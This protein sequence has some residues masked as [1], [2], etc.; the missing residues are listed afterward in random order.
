M[1]QSGNRFVAG[2]RGALDLNYA[3]AP[4]YI[5]L[6]KGS[7]V[8]SAMEGENTQSIHGLAMFSKYPMKNV[9]AVPLAEWQ[10][11]NVG[12]GKTARASTGPDR[13]YR[14][15]RQGCLGQ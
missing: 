13:R 5:P 2:D 15:S 4:V 9:H 11:Q 6:Q 7:G 3:F 8:E 14:S 12:Q 1:A 10:G